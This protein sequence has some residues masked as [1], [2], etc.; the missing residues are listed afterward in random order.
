[1]RAAEARRKRVHHDQQFHQVVVDRRAGG[2]DDIN[3]ATAHVFHDLDADLAVAET[4]GLNLTER[5]PEMPGDALGE[6][7]VGIAR[8]DHQF[9]I[10]SFLGFLYSLRLPL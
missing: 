6:P 4:R 7:R 1:M 2:L 3:I 8:K 5:Q 10:V 9:G